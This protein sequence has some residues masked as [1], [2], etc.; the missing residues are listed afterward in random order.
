MKY[1]RALSYLTYDYA[2]KSGKVAEEKIG[3]PKKLERLNTRGCIQMWKFKK[4]SF[5][6]WDRSVGGASTTQEL[7][8][9]TNPNSIRWVE[10]AVTLSE[11]RCPLPTH[12]SITSRMACY[13]H[14]Q[15]YIFNDMSHLLLWNQ[16]NL[17]LIQILATS[18]LFLFQ[19]CFCIV[20]TL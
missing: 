2:E 14:V 5:I 1:D 13:L 9:E 20:Q 18:F 11:I 15:R 10:M 6:R 4:Y 16:F 7:C 3:T 19:N 17:T 12:S 8:I